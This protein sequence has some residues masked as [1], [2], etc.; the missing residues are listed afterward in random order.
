[1]VVLVIVE[2]TKARMVPFFARDYRFWRPSQTETV[3]SW[4]VWAT[5]ALVYIPVILFLPCSRDAEVSE[6]S[7]VG[8][9]EER[10]KENVA[11]SV[12]F[13]M[14][15]LVALLW[16]LSFTEV[17]KSIASEL[18]PDFAYR[19]LGL[20]A[21]ISEVNANEVF[22]SDEDCVARA[23]ALGRSSFGLRDGRRSFPSGHS[24]I[25]AVSSVFVSLYITFAS[26]IFSTENIHGLGRWR[27]LLT[28]L[29][30]LLPMFIAL[31]VVVSR[32]VDNRHHPAD[33][34]AGFVLGSVLSSFFFGIAVMRDL[35]SSGK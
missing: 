31:G 11:R 16:T 21:Q 29:S 27:S 10:S 12:R 17:I 30:S 2:G 22:H 33:V 5:I 28:Q 24:S 32:L 34:T 14:W 26:S 3:P 4:V 13:A 23:Q 6:A 7:M 25:S 15:L 8:S 20:D 9:A 19:C 18:R 35:R 1:M